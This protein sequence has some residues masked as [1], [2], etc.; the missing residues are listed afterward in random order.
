MNGL[1]ALL[2]L[3]SGHGIW[4]EALRIRIP[5][6]QSLGA[7]P[8]SRASEYS[9]ITVIVI[10]IVR[11]TIAII[12]RSLTVVLVVIVTAIIVGRTILI[13]AKIAVVVAVI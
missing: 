2:S 11:L 7:L 9:N 3:R 1:V 10:L 12:G 4:A 5:H 13:L 8:V 6:S